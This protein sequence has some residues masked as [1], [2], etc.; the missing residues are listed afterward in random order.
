MPTLRVYRGDTPLLELDLTGERL[1][2]G[3]RPGDGVRLDELGLLGAVGSGGQFQRAPTGWTFT[4]RG[5]PGAAAIPLTDGQR[6]GVGEASLELLIEA[7]GPRVALSSLPQERASDLPFQDLTPRPG[8]SA[9]RLQS[10][11]DVLARIDLGPSG[12]ALLAHALDAAFGLVGAERGV[13]ARLEPDGQTL[14]VVA[15]KNLP[16]DD[17]RRALSRRVLETVLSEGRDVVTGDAPAEI[18]TVSVSLARIR[19]L[20][21]LPLRVRGRVV[22]LLYVDRGLLPVPFLPEDLAYLRLLA[23]LVARRLEEDERVQ[24]AERRTRAL[25]AS[26]SRRDED[27]EQRLG[28]ISP[29]MRRVRSEAQRILRA[30]Q[31]RSLPVLVTGESGTGKEVLARWLHEHLDER[32]RG[33]FV[34]LNCAAIP[35]DLAESELFGIEQGVASGVLKRMG[36]L[37]QAHGGTLFLDEVGE[38]TLPV[39]AKL[40]RALET[41]RITRVGG[42][43]EIPI[44]VRI[45]SATNVSLQDA[46]RGGRF[47]EDLYWRLTGVELR[48][49]PLRERQEDIAALTQTFAAHFA[50]EFGVSPPELT[51]AA[52]ERFHAWAWPGNVRELRQRVGALTALC[53]GSV[54]HV[55]DLPPELR[56]PGP[57]AAPAPP[58][59]GAAAPVAHAPA[60]GAPG[61]GGPA[62]LRTLAQVELDHIQ[63]VLASVGGD[64]GRAADILGIHRKTLGRR[65]DATGSAD[66]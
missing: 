10:L 63:R 18:P 13:A 27:E 24:A 23:A 6:I 30:F 54:V 64:R 32:V 50:T 55:E 42:R 36:R 35:H 53:G 58:V 9:S 14:R 41:H 31:G 17:P 51:A 48:L 46:I 45:V 38:M 61:M 26:L 28:W 11:A 66:A 65:L 62:D 39:Q 29:A 43:E 47:R 20:C 22:G 56:A 7:P 60:T 15:A 33:P 16:G 5:A 21:A 8:T 59:P 44:E 12:D 40:L 25:E 37:Q 4:P 34:P 52:L 19:A 3:D 1:E 57:R 49:P 2:V